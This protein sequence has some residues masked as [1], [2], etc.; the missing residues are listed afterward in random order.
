MQVAQVMSSPVVTVTLDATL[1][2][3]VR[4]MLERR[5]GSV[6]VLDTGPVGIVTR[7][8]ALWGTYQDGGSLADIAVTDVMSRD[9]V[10]TTEQTSITTALDTMKQ[11]EVKKLPVRDGMELVGIITMTD[12]AEHHPEVVHE[13]RNRISRKGDWSD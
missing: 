4:S 3:A 13:V 9:L 11:H 12:I 10:M 2:E 1:R 5:V 7:S 8:D 6:V